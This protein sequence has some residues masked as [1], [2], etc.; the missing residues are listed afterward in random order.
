MNELTSHQKAWI[1]RIFRHTLYWILNVLFLTIH[2]ASFSDF[3]DF[4]PMLKTDL[5]YLPGGMLFAYFSIYYLLPKYYFNN[6]TA[7]YIV[8]QLAVLVL[9]PVFSGFISRYLVSPYIFHKVPVYKFGDYVSMIFILVVGMVP[10]AWARITMR[11]TEENNLKRRLE[12]EK[13]EAQLKLRESELKLLKA[14]IHPHF[15]FNTLNNLYSLA[16]E[17]SERTPEV[18]IRISD[19]LNYIIYD[20]AEDR[21]TLEKE[22][23]FLHSYIELEKLRYDDSMKL[24][25]SVAGDFTNRVIA[26]MILHAFVENSFKHGASRDTGRPWISIIIEMRGDLLEFSVANSKAEETM[27][28]QPGIGIENVKRRLDLIYHGRYKLETSDKGKEYLVVLE[29]QL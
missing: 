3:Q 20:C 11:M 28:G 6:R 1:R 7:L 10:L 29:I 23:R 24:D 13:L 26:P 2:F 15:L 18:I 8:L 4:V 17:K 25:Y 14:Q 16:V 5:I 12:Q 22:I 19:L 27:A 21:V 9:Y